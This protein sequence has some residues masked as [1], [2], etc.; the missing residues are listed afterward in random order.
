MTTDVCVPLSK[1]PEMIV[2]TKQ[3]ID[4]SGM[5]GKWWC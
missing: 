3:D 4:S 1:L 2:Q 5:L